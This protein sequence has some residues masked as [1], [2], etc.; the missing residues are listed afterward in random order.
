MVAFVSTLAS[1]TSGNGCNI[2]SGI[3]NGNK[4][5]THSNVEWPHQSKPTKAYWETWEC[6]IRRTFDLNR[7][8]TLPKEFQLGRWLDI[9]TLTGWRYSLT[10]DRL[11]QKVNDHWEAKQPVLERRGRTAH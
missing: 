3:F 11:Y 8:C 4:I 9:T 10:E 6:A 7:N 2:V 5:R 1:I